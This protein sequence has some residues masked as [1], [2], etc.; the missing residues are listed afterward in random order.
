M[1]HDKWILPETREFLDKY[2][3]NAIE[4]RD[5]KYK[6]ENKPVMILCGMVIALSGL[7]TILS[8]MLF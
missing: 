6:D 7:V 1:L 8:L 5:K 2:I 3:Q 4:Q